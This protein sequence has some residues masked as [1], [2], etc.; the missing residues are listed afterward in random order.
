MRLKKETDWVPP[1]MAFKT[2]SFEYF[3]YDMEMD[4]PIIFGNQHLCQRFLTMFASQIPVYYFDKEGWSSWKNLAYTFT[5]RYEP[6]KQSV[7]TE[8]T[9]QNMTNEEQPQG[10]SA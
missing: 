1:F 2:T 4:Y 8:Q 6:K 3:I 10:S 5:A 9:N 7:T